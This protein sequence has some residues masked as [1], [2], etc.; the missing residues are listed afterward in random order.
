MAIYDEY[1]YMSHD[2]DLAFAIEYDGSKFT[3]GAR[4]AIASRTYYPLGLV[5]SFDGLEPEID[6]KTFWNIGSGTN[7]GRAAVV[8]VDG[9]HTIEGTLPVTLQNARIL[10]AFFGDDTS[11]KPATYYQHILP[12]ATPTPITY[13][14]TFTLYSKLINP[15]VAA[16]TFSRYYIGCVIDTLKF[17]G[18]EGSELKTDLGLKAMRAYV[19][20]SDPDEDPTTISAKTSTRPYMFHDAYFEFWGTEC[21]RVVSFTLNIRNKIKPIWY[22][23][24]ASDDLTPVGSDSAKYP[25]EMLYGK[26]EIDLSAKLVPVD[27]DLW[28]LLIGGG[29]HASNNTAV[30]KFARDTNDYIQFDLSGLHLKKAPYKIA[31]ENEVSAE[32]EFVVK[33]IKVTAQ[34][35]I[36][37]DYLTDVTIT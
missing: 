2:G 35:D 28:D 1:P 12:N 25:L 24:Q 15:L 11:T 8:S 27:R 18:D 16:N 37:K 3:P 20:T 7:A 14:K 5:G 6:V 22:F 19:N 4:A 21:A 32:T 10:A 17:S 30:I 33:N 29:E 36:S 34:D 13:P 9:K 23:R 26:L 31:E